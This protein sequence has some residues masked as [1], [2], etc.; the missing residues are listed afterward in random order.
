MS[1]K[2]V[3]I[4]GG[5]AG[6]EA[7]L[8]L[9]NSGI[10]VDLY[11]MRPV[12]NT[13]VHKTGNM[14]ELVCSN[15]LGSYS[16]DNASGVLKEEITR[17]GSSL[18]PMVKKFAVPAGGAL[19]TDRDLFSASV[20]S[21]I[22]DHPHINLIH[23]HV[24]DIH[25][26]RDSGCIVLVASGPLTTDELA[27]DISKYTGRDYLHFY[28]AVAP[29]VEYDSID[30]SIAYMMDRYNKTPEASY[31]N[32]P[33]TEAEYD[34]FYDF[35]INA[36]TI[37]LKE[38]EKGAGF[39]EGCMPVEVIASRG[40]DTLR[41][42]PMK[43]VGLPLP[44]TGKIPYAVVQLRQ[45]NATASLFNMV[46]FQTNLKWAAQKELLTLIPG[47][48]NANI[49][50]FGVMHRNTYINS[51][52]FL[53]PTLEA[54]NFSGLFF[55]GQLTGVEGYTESIATGLFAAINIKRL[56]DNKEL[57][58]PDD[59][60]VLGSLCHYITRADKKTFQPMNANWGIMPALE[61]N[62][63]IRDKKVRKQMYGER[64]LGLIDKLISL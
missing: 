29:I 27:N 59:K 8:Y 41:F 55:A 63:K 35:L 42:G 24:H 44:A 51:P 19:A 20:T 58:E 48:Q 10:K 33:M 2:V 15:S 53:N 9:A 17:L 5:L 16:L 18:I 30:M 56:I 37:E 23:E 61:S 60:T 32:C 14:A 34:A 54:K 46:G 39:F 43:P 28:D 6:S 7:A 1:K 4:G 40:K 52:E 64:A 45:D 49:V 26:Y 38:F 22:K 31:V 50:R 13:P 12:V 25:V 11:E 57:L 3:I 62:R 36:P 47:L 21:L